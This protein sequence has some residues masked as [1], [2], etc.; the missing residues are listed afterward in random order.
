MSLLNNSNLISG[1]T[2]VLH[3]ITFRS[4]NSYQE[5]LIGNKFNCVGASLSL[6]RFQVLVVNKLDAIFS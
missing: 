6:D 1:I 2:V 5:L 3:L 4:P